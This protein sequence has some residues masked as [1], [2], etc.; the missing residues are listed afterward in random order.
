MHARKLENRLP[1]DHPAVLAASRAP[2]EPETDEEREAVEAAL[3]SG[4]LVP[5]PMVKA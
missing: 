4:Q 2:V 3:G 5:G 1:D